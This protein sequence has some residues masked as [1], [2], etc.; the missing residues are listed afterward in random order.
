MVGDAG[1]VVSDVTIELVMV[2]AAV[3]AGPVGAVLG[4]PVMECVTPFLSIETVTGM[5]TTGEPVVGGGDSFPSTLSKS[6]SMGVSL[7]VNSGARGA[8]GVLGASCAATSCTPPRDRKAAKAETV[9]GS[10][11]NA[12]VF[13]LTIYNSRRCFPV[14]N[15]HSNQEPTYRRACDCTSRN[16]EMTSKEWTELQLNRHVESEVR[17]IRCIINKSTSLDCD[18][19]WTI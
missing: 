4:A 14:S 12:G 8:S 1:A 3:A 16:C 11:L 9:V 5:T 19:S 13:L 7:V 17:Q 6:F 15:R 2:E 18:S 10:M